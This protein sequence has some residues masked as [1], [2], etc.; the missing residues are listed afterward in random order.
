MFQR[1][2]SSPIEDGPCHLTKQPI[3]LAEEVIGGEAKYQPPSL[4]KC[5]D[6]CDVAPKL[7]SLTVMVALVLDGYLPFRV[8][9]IDASDEGPIRCSHFMLDDGYRE[10]GVDDE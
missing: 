2:G 10:A 3:R 6:A 8:C 5:V 7:V 1:A 9:Q 4:A